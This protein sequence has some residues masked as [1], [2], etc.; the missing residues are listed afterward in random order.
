MKKI[1]LIGG[2][3]WESTL[4]YYELINKK[5]KELLGGFHSS[6]CVIESV[7][8]AEIAA[9]QAKNDWTSLNQ[10]MIDKAKIL[11]VAG[12]EMIL[13]CA[14]TMHLCV[15]AIKPEISIPIVHIAEVTGQSI[16]TKGLDKVALLGTKFTME[17]DFFRN[18]LEEKGIAVILPNATDREIIHK[19]IYTELVKGEIKDVSRK[20]YIRIINLLKAQGAQ[21]VILG[22]TEIPLLI[23]KGDVDLP[24]FNTTKI[25]A[26]EAVRLSVDRN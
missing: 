15:E 6:K 20:E 13:I 8:F 17:K 9:F 5:V 3:S 19:I 14:N 7:D 26:E 24:L 11:E 12:A 10:M 4:L 25:H 2:M 22:C 16:R 1:G 21:G 23:K 18:I